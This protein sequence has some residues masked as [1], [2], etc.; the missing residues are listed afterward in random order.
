MAVRALSY[1]ETTTY[2]KAG[3]DI[4]SGNELVERIKSICGGKKVPGV[5]GG[6]GG[7]GG[8]FDI[9]SLGYKHPLL[10]AGTDGVGT[11]LMVSNKSSIYFL[12][13]YDGYVTLIFSS[14]CFF[15]EEK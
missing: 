8:L 9:H 3:V 12:S 6:I 7:F 14:E 4:D 5:I 2:K 15:L 11:K 1:Q 10:V 13:T